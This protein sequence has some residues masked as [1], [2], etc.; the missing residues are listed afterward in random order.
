MSSVTLRENEWRRLDLS[1]VQ[2]EELVATGQELAGR[3]THWRASAASDNAVNERSVI[4][5]V[6]AGAGQFKISVANAI[7]V[8]ALTG[9]TIRVVPK[10]NLDHFLFIASHA[11][12]IDPR[13]SDAV[14][15]VDPDSQLHEVLARALIGEAQRSLRLGLHRGYSD[16]PYEAAA[17]RGRVDMVATSRQVLRGRMRVRGHADEFVADTP[18]NRLVKEA[19]RRISVSRR[20]SGT[21]TGSA[22]M[23]LADFAEIG[24]FRST[25]LAPTLSRSQ[26]VFARL[27]H[28]ARVVVEAGG[29]GIAEGGTPVE[30]FLISTPGLVE[31]GVRQVLAT[32]LAPYEIQ[33]QG[34]GRVLVKAPNFSVHPDLLITKA[35]L[36]GDV[37]YQVARSGWNRSAVA[38]AVLFAA[39]YQSPVGFIVGFTDREGDGLPRLAVGSIRV[40][41]LWWPAIPAVAPEAAARMV[42]A[43]LRD[44]ILATPVTAGAKDARPRVQSEAA[45]R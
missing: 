41:E 14:A 25:D 13:L 12:E 9:L 4:Q 7:G 24:R 2:L 1:K 20:L 5:I 44:A 35:P 18:L 34:G 40:H 6:A 8:V 37:K 10:I 36:T 26:T 15:K 17:V 32:H 3:K 22:R 31:A 43:Q 16:R 38:Q 30:S 23:M 29:I 21:T 45:N 39:A 27:V 42:A 11:L 19:L 28:L 33:K